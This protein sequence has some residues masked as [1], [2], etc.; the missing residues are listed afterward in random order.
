MSSALDSGEAF[1]LSTAAIELY[2]QE[3]GMLQVV[4]P[5]VLGVQ[6]A[7][8]GYFAAFAAASG[9]VVPLVEGTA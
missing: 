1:L 7:F 8:G 3:I 4:E 9:A 6:V 2:E 5:S